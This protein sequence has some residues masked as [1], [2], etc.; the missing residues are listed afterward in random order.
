MIHLPSPRLCP[1]GVV[2]RVPVEHDLARLLRPYEAFYMANNGKHAALDGFATEATHGSLHTAFSTT[3]TNEVTGGS[4]AY[5]RKALTW[6]A[7]SGGAKALA[8]TLPTWDVPAGT[9]VA[10]VGFWDAITTGNFSGMIPAGGGTLLNAMVEVSGD[11]TNNDIFSKAHGLVA[12][13]RVVFWGTLPTGLS[14]GTIYYV[15]ATGLATDSFRVSTSS[16]G[17]AVDITGTA[18]F[19]FFAQ[20]CV[21]ETFAGQGTYALSSGSIDLAA[22]A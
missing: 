21:P 1:C 14:V 17:S 6:A 9:T 12:D 2:H 11:I 22:V 7:S 10:W 3:G 8:A 4:P 16:G 20:K 15:I 19:G 5:A 18:P 13:N